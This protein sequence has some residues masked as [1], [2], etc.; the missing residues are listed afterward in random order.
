M[1]TTNLETLK[2]HKLTKAQYE[3]ELAAGNIDASALYLTP[4]E[5]IDPRY[6]T[7]EN[8]TGTGSFSLNRKEN[9]TIG[10]YSTAIGYNTI[11]SGISSYASG[12]LSQATGIG[13]YAEGSGTISEGHYSHAEGVKSKASGHYSHAEG[14]VLN[15]SLEQLPD[16]TFYDSD[17]VEIATISG[18]TTLGIQSHA[19]GTQTLAYG[20]S[21]HAEGY[22]TLAY[23]FGAHAE[24][25]DTLASSECQHVQ[26]RFN[27]DD[28][29]GAYAHIVGNGED[30]DSRSNAHTLDWDGNA[31]FAG[32]VTT[33]A[34][35]SLNRMGDRF[36]YI[37]SFSCSSNS[38]S[39]LQL[40][41]SGLY[42]IFTNQ[43]GNISLQGMAFGAATGYS[44]GSGV[45]KIAG[46][47]N[48]TNKLTFSIDT[49]KVLT[50]TST[51]SG[52]FYIYVYKM[53]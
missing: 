33:E 18:S 35:A 17:D 27:I 49:S 47:D 4:E 7:K 41:S 15:T 34:G 29:E 50:V 30:D 9:T 24:G 32:D 44:G 48:F 31:W 46:G 25:Q 11:A 3:R 26:G 23:G 53:T 14:G 20:Y 6:M 51:T 12:H 22:Q 39:T 45:Y 37:G 38:S 36:S 28:T 42:L 5:E 10:N 8:P 2:I 19:E 40:P 52:A 21:S 16:Y 1:L 13:S 43:G